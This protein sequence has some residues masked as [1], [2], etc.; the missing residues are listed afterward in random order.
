MSK[1]VTL[2]KKKKKK[3]TEK[4]VF[5]I[6]SPEEFLILYV[7][8]DVTRNSLSLQL[9]NINGDIPKVYDSKI[10]N[11]SLSRIGEKRKSKMAEPI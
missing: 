8:K 10:Y 11:F 4:E 7:K 3:K 9:T 1:L 5:K 6:V 2:T